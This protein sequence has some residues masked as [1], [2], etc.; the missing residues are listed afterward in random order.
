LDNAAIDLEALKRTRDFIHKHPDAI[1]NRINNLLSQG[2]GSGTERER[3]EHISEALD[4]M[5]AYTDYMG[6]CLED[7]YY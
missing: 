6:T 4:L 2:Y 1:V 5:D 3:E 7:E